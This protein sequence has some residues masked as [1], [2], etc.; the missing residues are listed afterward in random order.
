VKVIRILTNM[1]MDN[2]G[3]LS[4]LLGKSDVPEIHPV[5]NSTQN[6]ACLCL[7]LAASCRITNL[8]G[9]KC[10]NYNYN[11]LFCVSGTEK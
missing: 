1:T 4:G 9:G 3:N 11:F 2:V 10:K 6:C 7:V 8:K 5:G